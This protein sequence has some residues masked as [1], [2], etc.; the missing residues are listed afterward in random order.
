MSNWLFRVGSLSAAS[1]IIIQA[2]GGHKPWD[3]DRKM[4]FNKAFDLHLSSAIGMILC[5][6]RSK[7]S[8]VMIPGTLF[9]AGTFLFSATAYYRCFS[10]DRKFNFMMPPGGSCI[11]LAWILFAFS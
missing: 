3:I 5:S 10:N 2:V 1:S 8:F 7:S 4:I 9:L 6:L 11:I